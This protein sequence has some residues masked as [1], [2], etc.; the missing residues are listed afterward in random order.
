MIFGAIMPA[1]VGF[2]NSL[3]PV[4]I[5]APDMASTRMNNFSFWLPAGRCAGAGD[6]DRRCA[7]F[8]VARVAPRA[9]VAAMNPRPFEAAALKD[10]QPASLPQRQQQVSLDSVTRCVSSPTT[11]MLIAEPARQSA[12]PNG[13]IRCQRYCAAT[14]F[15]AARFCAIL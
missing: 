12:T 9:D 8:G 4:Q 1:F 7:G 11:F 6:G 3:I 10:E 2:A 14:P 5:S 13:R 15:F